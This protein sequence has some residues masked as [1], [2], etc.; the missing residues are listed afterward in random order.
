MIKCF[1]LTNRLESNR[2][3][4]FFQVDH[5]VIAIKGFLT[6][7]KTPGLKSHHQMQFSVISRTHIG[8]GGLTP[9]QR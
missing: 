3:Y 5:G 9:L 2:C 7:P 4:H 6:F 8:G 1:Y